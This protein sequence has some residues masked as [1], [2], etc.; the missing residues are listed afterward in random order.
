[1]IH[2]LGSFLTSLV[3]SYL[4]RVVGYNLAWILISI[5]LLPF[6]IPILV[7]KLDRGQPNSGT[8]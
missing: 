6:M 4:A 8:G 2:Y 1:M 5:I 3:F 7:A